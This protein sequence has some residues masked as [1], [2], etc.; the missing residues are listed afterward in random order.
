[1]VMQIT[2]TYKS[3]S[4]LNFHMETRRTTSLQF[5]IKAKSL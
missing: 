5:D 2:Y 4:K 3:V 1:M